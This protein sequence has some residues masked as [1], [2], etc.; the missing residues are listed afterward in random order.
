MASDDRPVCISAFY[1]RIRGGGGVFI[2]CPGYFLCCHVF[3]MV[4]ELDYSLLE[5]V[6]IN[7]DFEFCVRDMSRQGGSW[8]FCYLIGTSTVL[9]T[10]Q[11]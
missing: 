3:P 2:L 1:V 4:S 9:I 5:H 8:L 6:V 11:Y 7:N 10:D